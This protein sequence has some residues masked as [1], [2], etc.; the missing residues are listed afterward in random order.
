MK[1]IC[2]RKNRIKNYFS[3]GPTYLQLQTWFGPIDETQ[4]LCSLCLT[5]E[6][7]SNESPAFKTCILRCFRSKAQQV[8]FNKYCL[9]VHVCVCV[10]A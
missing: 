7:C 3:I 4:V 1:T 6:P 10:C 5:P 9:C 2:V 8:M